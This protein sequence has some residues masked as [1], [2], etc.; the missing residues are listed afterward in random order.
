MNLLKFSHP[1]DQ[2]VSFFSFN[3][4][5]AESCLKKNNSK[6]NVCLVILVP[7]DWCC[8]VVSCFA[9]RQKN[10]GSHSDRSGLSSE[11]WQR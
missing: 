5:K 3:L 8:A 11:R 9:K 4:M 10:M 7:S 1:I 2:T 6:I